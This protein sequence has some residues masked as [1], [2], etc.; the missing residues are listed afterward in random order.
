[1]VAPT[2]WKIW[3]IGIGGIFSLLI[4][5]N[6][7]FSGPSPAPA[8]PALPV[9][10]ELASATAASIDPAMLMNKAMDPWLNLWVGLASVAYAYW[11][12]SRKRKK[13]G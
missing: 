13:R 11:G 5:L 4:A 9:D 1:M 6:G 2:P 3:P 7:V 10:P 8:V 12:Y